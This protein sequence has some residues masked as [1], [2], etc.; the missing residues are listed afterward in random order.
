TKTFPVFDCDAHINDPNEIWTT[1]VAPEYRE[2]VRTAYWK[3]ETQTLL[4][5]RTPPIGGGGYEFPS[6]NPI[7]I[8]G[9]QMDKRVMRKLQQMRLTAEQKRYLEHPGAYDPKAR[10]K[11][12]D[13]MGIDQVMIIPTMLV[14]NYPFIENV[15]AAHALARAYNDW[16][17]DFCSAAPDRLFPAGWLPL[18][19][20]P[21]TCQELERIAGMGFRVALV[22]PIDARG[23]Y[24]NYIF[25]TTT[26]GAPTSTM[27]RVFRTFE[28]TGIVLGMHTFPANNPEMGR[29]VFL[30]TPPLNV[31]SP[32]ALIVRAGGALGGAGGRA[33][34]A[35]AR[36]GARRRAGGWRPPGPQLRLRGG[37]LARAGTA[38]GDARPLSP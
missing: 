25:P 19:N 18:Q 37:G 30:T 22:R 8:A 1:Y 12:M 28:E 32:G 26:G 38:L 16:A 5:G 9:P 24:P 33:A 21:Y 4:N 17:K 10:L 13:L 29:G 6:Y 23:K 15:E 27:D 2:L 20:V 3:D 34:R 11:E 14:M 35:A 31:T 36:G 7:C